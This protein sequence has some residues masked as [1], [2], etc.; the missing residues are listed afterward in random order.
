MREQMPNGDVLPRIG[1]V[2]KEAIDLVVEAEFAF[3]N[4]HENKRGGELFGDRADLEY[5]VDSRWGLQFDVGQT[6]GSGLCNF[7]V[8]NDR[9]NEARDSPLIHLRFDVVV[10]LVGKCRRGNEAYQ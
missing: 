2:V 4:E 7:A 9:E 10:D 8:S 5:R 1:C 3:I 6:A